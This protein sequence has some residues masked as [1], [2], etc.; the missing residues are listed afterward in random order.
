MKRDVEAVILKWKNNEER[1]AVDDE[2]DDDNLPADIT[3]VFDD[4]SAIEKE[5]SNLA[6]NPISAHAS[7]ISDEEGT[8][9]EI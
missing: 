9:V 3:S 1:R 7:V 8:V 4:P 5:I 6:E 2:S